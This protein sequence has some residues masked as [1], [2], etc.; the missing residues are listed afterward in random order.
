MGYISKMKVKIN[1]YL[2]DLYAAGLEPE[3]GEKVFEWR[4]K[5]FSETHSSAFGS[6]KSHYTTSNVELRGKYYGNPT[7]DTKSRYNKNCRD[8]ANS[9]YYNKLFY[10]GRAKWETLYIKNCFVIREVELDNT[11][12]PYE[13]SK[14]SR[15]DS[16][17]SRNRS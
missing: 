8:K 12:I 5:I 17:N 16:R 15:T 13:N 7:L 2:T 11:I 1:I 14:K 6:H 10:Y 9:Q 3:I 4:T